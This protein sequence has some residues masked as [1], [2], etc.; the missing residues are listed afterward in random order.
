MSKLG[1]IARQQ[2]VLLHAAAVAAHLRGLGLKQQLLEQLFVRCLELFSRPPKDRAEGL[3]SELMSIGLTAAEA[4]RCFVACPGAAQSISFSG[5]IAVADEMMSRSQDSGRG[6]NYSQDTLRRRAAALAEEFG[7]DE[8]ASI[9][10]RNLMALDCDTSVWQRNLHYMA[11]CGV[12]NARAVLLKNPRPIPYDHAAPDFVAR[13]LLLQRYT[14]LSARQLYQQH[15]CYLTEMNLKQLALQL[16]Y[17]EH[18]LSSLGD[19]QQQARGTAWPGTLRQLTRNLEGFLAAL[20]G[21][22][23]EWDVFAAAH[24]AGSGPVWEWAQEAAGPEVQ[25]RLA[26]CL[27]SYGRQRLT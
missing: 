9:V 18:Q 25:R 8:A 11:A 13:R 21:S 7:R 12:G 3:F 2:G 23:Q 20:G 6:V 17:V 16:Q 24:S 14:G 4:A 22:Q 26:C 19:G 10:M 15:A 27:V 5:I 1:S